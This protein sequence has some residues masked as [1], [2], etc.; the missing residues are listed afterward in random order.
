MSGNNLLKLYSGNNQP[1]LS[2]KAINLTLADIISLTDTSLLNASMDSINTN[3]DI[4]LF[5]RNDFLFDVSENV[6]LF[7]I[8]LMYN[9]L[10]ATQKFDQFFASFV[11][12]NKN[13]G[14]TTEE[15]AILNISNSNDSIVD[16]TIPSGNR[17]TIFSKHENGFSYTNYTIFGSIAGQSVQNDSL[18]EFNPGKGRINK[19]FLKGRIFRTDII[20]DAK[21]GYRE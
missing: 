9:G 18:S 1:I 8:Q 19:I 10:M 3:G 5:G 4:S 7:K 14:A 17:N 12:G 13:A 15:Y 11:A 16:L 20:G 6:P 21:Y 2:D